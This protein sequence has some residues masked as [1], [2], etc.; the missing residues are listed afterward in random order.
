MIFNKIFITFLVDEERNYTTCYICQGLV[1][2][3][4]EAIQN[5]NTI[6]QVKKYLWLIDY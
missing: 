3:V 6:S 4:D 5:N 1:Q 2:L